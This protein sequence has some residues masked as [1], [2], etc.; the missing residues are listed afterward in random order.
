MI[1]RWLGAFGHAGS[2]SES[3]SW[4]L[5]QRERE[6]AAERVATSRKV[7]ELDYNKHGQVYER[8]VH[9]GNGNI[10]HAIIGL[11]LNKQAVIRYFPGDVWSVIREDGCLIPTRH[12]KPCGHTEVFCRPGFVKAL[13]V[14]KH[15]SQLSKDVLI[16]LRDASK[17]HDLDVFLLTSKGKRVL[18]TKEVRN[19]KG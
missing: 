2:L 14:K 11:W 18:V 17:A 9:A 6:V 16:A 5:S 3:L 1:I 12:S 4:E 15:P 13:I 8:L 19:Y 10:Q 7:A